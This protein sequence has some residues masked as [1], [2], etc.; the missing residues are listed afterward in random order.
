MGWQ[1]R[2][3]YRDSGSNSGNPL[4]WL[5]TGSVP[6]FTAFGIR[7]RAHASLVI[8]IVLVLLF[9]LGQ[10]FTWQDRVQS[11]SILFTIVLLHEFG[12]C[13]TARWVGGEANDI[14]MHPLGGLA[15]TRPPHRPLPEF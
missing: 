7:V 11:M 5:M 3:Y 1:D 6:L 8:L 12:H 13:F 10:G 2:S 9:G 15:F 14:L 4:M